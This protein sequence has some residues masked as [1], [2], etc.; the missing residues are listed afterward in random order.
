MQVRFYVSGVLKENGNDL[1]VTTNITF[2]DQIEF[3]LC[4]ILYDKMLLSG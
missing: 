3:L 1:L 4:V 2:N